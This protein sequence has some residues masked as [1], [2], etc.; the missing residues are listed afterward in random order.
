MGTNAVSQPLQAGTIEIN[1]VDMDEIG[2]D[3]RFFSAGAEQDLLFFLI[4]KEYV[5]DHPCSFGN[6]VQNPARLAAY[7]V[8][9]VPAVAFRGPEDLFAILHIITVTF[10]AIADESR[11]GFLNQG[12]DASVGAAHFKDPVNLVSSLVVF[13]GECPAVLPPFKGTD[14]E[15]LV[16]QPVICQKLF[17]TIQNEQSRNL[18]R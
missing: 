15:L 2:I 10:A 12:A 9:V 5:A 13:K 17:F 4:H 1:P 8:Q 6:L 11:A 14:I 7:P 18:V 16:K 3:T